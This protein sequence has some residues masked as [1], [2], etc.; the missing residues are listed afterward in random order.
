MGGSNPI[1]DAVG[2]AGAPFTNGA[3]LAL[4][5]RDVPVQNSFN[6]I[7]GAKNAASNAKTAAAEQAAQTASLNQQLLEQPKQISPDNFLA[8]KNRLLNNMRLGLASTIT[9]G[10]GT[11]SPVLSA[12]AL[13]G[14]P[15]KKT[16]GS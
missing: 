14:A 12:P 10:A 15:G 4:L 3:A 5:G 2:I 13:T 1:N 9:S 7:G 6:D 8:T 16:L 11:P